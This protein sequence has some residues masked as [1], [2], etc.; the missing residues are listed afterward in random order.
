MRITDPI[1]TLFPHHSM[2]WTLLLILL[3]AAP[4]ARAADPLSD[5]LQ[6]GLLAEEVHHDLD[7]AIAAYQ[8]VVTPLFRLGECYRKQGKTTDAIVQYQRLL[9]EFSDQAELARLSRQNLDTLGAGIS[10]PTGPLTPA[11]Q[12]QKDLLAQELV[13][14][15]QQIAEVR[16]KISVGAA[17]TIDLIPLQREALALKR[18]MAALDDARRPDLLRDVVLPS[19]STV[20][21]PD[22]ADGIGEEEMREIERLKEMI[23]NSPDL[24]NTAIRGDPPLHAAAIKGQ[25]AVAR[26]LIQQGFDAN[27][28]D[29]ARKSPLHRAVEHGHKGMT[30]IFL[31]AKADVNAADNQQQTP[32]HIAAGLGFE[33]I[34]KVLLSA[35]ADANAAAPAGTP[36]HAAVM[37]G[38]D[39]MIDLLLDHGADLEARTADTFTP[40]P[41]FTPLLQAVSVNYDLAVVER[42]L[43]HRANIRATNAM[44][45][46]VLHIAAEKGISLVFLR[47]AGE[48]GPDLE[49]R[50][51]Q[52]LTPLQVACLNGNDAAARLLLELGANPNVPFDRAGGRSVELKRAPEAPFS[53]LFDGTVLGAEGR[54]VG[55]R[56]RADGKTPL[57][58]AAATRNLKLM[59]LLLEH[60]ADPN[61]TDHDGLTPLLCAISLES[62]MDLG[63]VQLLL[64]SGADPNVVNKDGMSLLQHALRIGSIDLV[65]A[66]LSKGVNPNTADSTG[67]TPVHA[68]ALWSDASAMRLLLDHG[69]EIDLRGQFGNTPLHIAAH[70]SN[71]EVVRLLLE[72]GAPVNARNKRNQTPLDLTLADFTTYR[73][74]PGRGLEEPTMPGG[75]TRPRE[76]R[77]MASSATEIAELLI[78]HGAEGSG[79]NTSPQSL[80]P[81]IPSDNPGPAVDPAL[82]VI[83]MRLKEIRNRANPRSAAGVIPWEKWNP[84][85]VD[86][87]R[88]AGH[89]V[90]VSFA[91]DW[92]VSCQLNRETSLEIKSVADKLKELNAAMFLGDYT[93]KDPVI[94]AEL[95][96]HGRSSVPLVLVY[97]RNPE[98]PPRMLSET[99]TPAIVLEALDWAAQ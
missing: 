8:S 58:W 71:K 24:I 92:C 80:S 55:N 37:Q 10:I 39:A 26:F 30:E 43:A 96:R 60:G 40:M 52:N 56:L 50:G 98:T 25:L 48:P 18:Q 85:V 15:E 13:L 53:P 69:A 44:G 93:E 9:A 14:V 88:A 28:R 41:G 74:I 86:Q 62:R 32:L 21:S 22:P 59:Q 11:A 36:L 5:T 4:A 72:R 90:L 33:E 45:D 94:T 66:F 19:T 77:R 78:K 51:S 6:Q 29:S 42:L 57:H 99:L 16:A 2:T 63:A 3:L 84:E 54:V 75:A 81:S 17:G 1:H 76:P 7:A 79:N 12:R 82:S 89:P 87:A 95:Q 46:T 23:R 73:I 68:A 83:E 49:A 70:A 20:D 97:P 31:A 64:D 27:I 91:A 38:R 47:A 65:A 35:G 34:A 67:A 61:A